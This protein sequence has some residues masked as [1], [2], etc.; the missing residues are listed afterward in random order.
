MWRAQR[1]SIQRHHQD[2]FREHEISAPDVVTSDVHHGSREE[3]TLRASDSS[4]MGALDRMRRL[5]ICARASAPRRK[6]KLLGSAAGL[7]ALRCSAA[8]SNSMRVSPAEK[9]L[10]MRAE[11]R[12]ALNL[13]GTKG[14]LAVIG[15]IS[16]KGN[17]MC[18]A[19][20]TTDTP[21]L[22]RFG[23]RVTDKTGVKLSRPMSTG[24]YRLLGHDLQS[25]RGSPRPRRILVGATYANS[26]E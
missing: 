15:A 7:K 8:R 12:K 11:K 10:N 23:R 13:S 6:R 2:H 17:V 26:I 20:E 3:R 19:I 18:Q 22:D 14:K 21:T 16:R 5:G 24:G 9:A 1:L 4:H 25:S